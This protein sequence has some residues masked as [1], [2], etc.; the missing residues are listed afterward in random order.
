MNQQMKVVRHEAVRTNVERETSR[1]TKDFQPHEI[2]FGQGSEVRHTL[3]RAHRQGIRVSATVFEPANSR[4]THAVV[5]V[6]QVP[7]LKARPTA[8]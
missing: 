4:R 2:D 7:G 6:R 5:G 8:H 3:E 1:R